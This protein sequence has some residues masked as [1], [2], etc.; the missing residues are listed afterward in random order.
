MKNNLYTTLKQLE[1]SSI[2]TGHHYVQVLDYLRE[3]A[4][5]LTYIVEPFNNHLDN[6]HPAM[7]NEQEIE[8]MRVLQD[9][10]SFYLLSGEIIKNDNYQDVES[11][12]RLN[13]GIIEK[14]EELKKLQV[15]LIK[16]NKVKTKNSL[17]FF[18]FL[19]ETKNMLLFS[20]NL[21]K[22]HRDFLKKNGKKEFD[23]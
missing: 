19:S 14:L 3:I 17:V 12:V 18:N 13:A 8:V 11:L 22:S 23:Y 15:K 6:V 16:A 7:I 5:C 1:K 20:I 4:H 9:V 21:V 2:E 10:N